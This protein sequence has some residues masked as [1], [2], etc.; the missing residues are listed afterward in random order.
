[1]FSPQEDESLLGTPYIRNAPQFTK[2]LKE[3]GLGQLCFKK[4]GEGLR[5]ALPRSITQPERG[6]SHD[7]SAQ[8][9]RSR[10]RPEFCGML[11][12]SGALIGILHQGL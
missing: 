8:L 2:P 1:M 3:P 6:C 11:L 12:R 7:L 5:P 9:S 10:L 4:L